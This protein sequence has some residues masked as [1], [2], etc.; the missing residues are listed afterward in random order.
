MS[1]LNKWLV[2]FYN[3]KQLWRQVRLQ[4]KVSEYHR[5]GFYLYSDRI[6]MPFTNTSRPRRLTRALLHLFIFVL[7]AKRNGCFFLSNPSYALAFGLH[8]LIVCQ[9]VFHLLRTSRK[10]LVIL[11]SDHNALRIP[12]TND[13]ENWN[14][15][16]YWQNKKTINGSKICLFDGERQMNEINLFF[17]RFQFWQFY[18]L[19]LLL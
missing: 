9:T 15:H 13:N 19:H 10:Q 18:L 16:T 2:C 1:D 11:T 7:I 4:A 6:R 3:G 5:N 8:K 17:V 14:W 12:M